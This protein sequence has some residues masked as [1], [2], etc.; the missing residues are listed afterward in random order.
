MAIALAPWSTASSLKVA[1]L[2]QPG[3]VQSNDGS[4]IEVGVSTGGSTNAVLHLIAMARSTGIQ[5]SL[6]DWQRVSDRVPFMADL[7]P[8]G[9]C[10][11]AFCRVFLQ[12]NENTLQVYPSL[13]SNSKLHVTGS[14]V[15]GDVEKA[16]KVT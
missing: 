13:P 11:A 10:A 2:I 12:T 14:H 1:G 3:A 8:S 15:L 6:D 4:L 7:R 5:L 9:K 16:L